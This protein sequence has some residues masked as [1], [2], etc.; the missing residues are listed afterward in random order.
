ASTQ[1]I[2]QR[3]IGAGLFTEWGIMNRYTAADFADSV[4]WTSDGDGSRP[5]LVTTDD[6]LV[7]TYLPGYNYNGVCA[8]P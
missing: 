6:G 3:N 2:Y 5:F 7:F 8:Y 4:V 1:D